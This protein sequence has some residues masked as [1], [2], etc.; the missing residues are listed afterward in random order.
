MVSVFAVALGLFTRVT[1][2]GP[3]MPEF[4]TT[5]SEVSMPGGVIDVV[6]PGPAGRRYMAYLPGLTDRQ[7][8]L[9]FDRESGHYSA[10]IGVPLFAPERGFCT[11]RIVSEARDESDHRV[12]LRAVLD[13][14]G[15]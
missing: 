3:A 1:F 8:E 12:Q 2:A 6:V 10:R 7:I 15:S 9:S 11:L 13:A 14:P 4:Q 5:V